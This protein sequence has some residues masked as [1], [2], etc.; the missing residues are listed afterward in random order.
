[1]EDGM[2]QHLLSLLFLGQ[3]QAFAQQFHGGGAVSHRGVVV[4]ALIVA[5]TLGFA[6]VGPSEASS[7]GSVAAVGNFCFS[8]VTVYTALPCNRC[9]C[10]PLGAKTLA[11]N[12]RLKS[13][14]HFHTVVWLG[15]AQMGTSSA[16]ASEYP[17]DPSRVHDMLPPTPPLRSKPHPRRAI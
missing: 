5:Q 15:H 13:D 10:T 9:P 4:N 17:C 12:A 16:H 1:M 8:P 3:S 6:T 2:R 11:L 14:G 7:Q